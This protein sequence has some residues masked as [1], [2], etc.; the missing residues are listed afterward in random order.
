MRPAPLPQDLEEYRL[1]T[2]EFLVASNYA[3]NIRLRPYQDDDREDLPDEEFAASVTCLF[4]NNASF[5]MPVAGL[6]DVA[7]YTSKK[8]ISMIGE[9]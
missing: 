8:I 9:R 4:A 1:P 6:A 7:E 2:E 5:F 3:S